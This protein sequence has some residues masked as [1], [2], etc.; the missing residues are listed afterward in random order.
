MEKKISQILL[1]GDMIKKTQILEMEWL[2][3][4]GWNEVYWKRTEIY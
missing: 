4:N 3:A 1:N 2:Q